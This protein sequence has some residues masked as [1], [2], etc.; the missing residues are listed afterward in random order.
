M[1]YALRVHTDA[2]YA[3]FWYAFVELTPELL[4]FIRRVWLIAIPA[5]KD[6]RSDFLRVEYFDGN[7]AFT[8]QN[9]PEAFDRFVTCDEFNDNDRV[10]VP[11]TLQLPDGERVELATLHIEADGFRWAARPKHTEVDCETAT[12][13]Y[14]EIFEDA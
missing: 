10:R 13:Y 6:L 11:D 3:P 2:E 5:L 7:C 8:G 9:C 4:E 12:I 14:K 1:K